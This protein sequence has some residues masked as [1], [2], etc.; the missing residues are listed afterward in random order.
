MK[1]LFL[2]RRLEKGVACLCY[3]SRLPDG[4]LAN[5]VLAIAP[6]HCGCQSRT[7]SLAVEMPERWT[8][9]DRIAMVIKRFK[10]AVLP[11]VALATKDPIEFSEPHPGRRIVILKER[12]PLE[13]LYVF[14]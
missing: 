11:H 8:A 12:Q 4:S 2:K 13:S 10:Q 14:N 9:P 5:A 7:W 6:C 3:E 1:V